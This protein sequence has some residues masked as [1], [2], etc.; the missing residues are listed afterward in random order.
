MRCRRGRE[1]FDDKGELLPGRQW[2][3]S[4]AGV[5]VDAHRKTADVVRFG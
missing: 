1:L 3:D 2:P 5:T 4:V